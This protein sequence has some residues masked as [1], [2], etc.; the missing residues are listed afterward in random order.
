MNN[1][2]KKWAH[3]RLANELH[4]LQQ[5]EAGQW[6]AWARRVNRGESPALDQRRMY[7]DWCLTAVL[8]ALLPTV[9]KPLR[10]LVQTCLDLRERMWSEA[11]MNA[12]YDAQQQTSP[13]SLAASDSFDGKP[14]QMHMNR[15]F[16]AH[17]SRGALNVQ[18]T[19][20]TSPESLQAMDSLSSKLLS[21]LS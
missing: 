10:V 15:G 8:R 20:K 18:D 12:Y 19:Q 2:Q 6:P 3:W 16:S 1:E 5:L 14:C 21:D 7:A 4:E 17:C 13:E 11:Y 9:P